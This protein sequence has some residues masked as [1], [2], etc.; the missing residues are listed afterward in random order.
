MNFGPGAGDEGGQIVYAGK[1]KEILSESHNNS[2]ITPKKEKA[3]K[4][5]SIYKAHA[6]N[7]QNIDVDIPSG[8]MTVISGVSGS[9]KTSLLDKVIYDSYSSGKAVC[10]ERI[11]GFDNFSGLVYIEQTALGK[12]RNATTGSMLG[13]SEVISKIFAATDDSKKRGFKATHF[14]SGS[15]DSRCGGCEGTG[16]IQ[17]SMDFFS[18]IVTPCEHCGGSGFKDETLEIMIDGKNIWDVLQ[19]TFSGL[20]S[21]IYAYL[22][23]KAK[24][25]VK[26]VLEL[27]GKTGLGH[28]SSG[29]LLKTLSTGE[30]QRLKLP[31][32]RSQAKQM[33]TRFSCWTNP[34]VACIPRILNN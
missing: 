24:V 1:R 29:R 9:G 17:V 13:I 8:I 16:Y 25:Q 12:G 22:Q 7:L 30:L 18:D 23:G 4:G 11:S 28:L 6:N 27:I 31:C 5:L 33:I 20:Y 21:F 34:Q 19:I 10:C 2:T 14:I 32:E 26:A 15:K 3:G